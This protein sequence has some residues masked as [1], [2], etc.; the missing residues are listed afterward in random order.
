MEIMMT[1]L[2]GL[3][4]A[5]MPTYSDVTPEQHRRN[6]LVSALNEQKAMAAAHIEGRDLVVTKRRWTKIDGGEKTLVDVPKRLKRWWVNDA[7]GNCVI[8]VRYGNK[9]L[10]LEKGKAAIVVG[11]SDK[12]IS[13]I[14]TIISAVNAG[15]LDSH[16]SAMG[17]DRK[18]KKTKK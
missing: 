8:S 15:E 12:L 16:L 6:K 9:V 4:Y 1:I 18:I 11:K 13:T 2:K 17:M 7:N 5:A 10:E 14:E 3:S